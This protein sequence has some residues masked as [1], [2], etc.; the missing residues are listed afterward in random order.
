MSALDNIYAVTETEFESKVIVASHQRPVVV[1]FFTNSCPACKKLR[2]VLEDV[3]N[4]YGGAVALALID[5]GA[6]QALA[7]HF[8]IQGVPAVKIFKNGEIITE[9]AGAVGRAD[10]EC[11]FKKILPSEEDKLVEEAAGLHVDGYTQAAVEKYRQAL[12]QNSAHS[13]AKIG[14][15]YILVEQ[16]E[17]DEAKQLASS[18]PVGTEEYKL[19]EALLAQLELM[20]IC[21]AGL[22]PTTLTKKLEDNPDDLETRFALANCLASGG[23]YEA[24]LE[25]LLTIIKRDKNFSEGAA[26][27]AMVRVFA[28][29]GKQSELASKYRTLLARALY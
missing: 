29:A 17:F 7:M 3:I 14:L 21:E 12:K 28:L 13:A 16:K 26:K 23:E 20:D 4:S 22:D 27:E 10:L 2:P 6:E 5:A 18:V 19:A 11:L 9:F 1:D 15:A 25:D 24:A 8:Q